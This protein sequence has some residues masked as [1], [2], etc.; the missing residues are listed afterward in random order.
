MVEDMDM[1]NWDLNNLN[2]YFGVSFF[3][4]VGC[5]LDDM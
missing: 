2:S 4:F 1:I 5:V 3:F